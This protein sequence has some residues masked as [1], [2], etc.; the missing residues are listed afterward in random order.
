MVFRV[1][2]LDDFIEPQEKG[3]LIDGGLGSTLISIIY[4]TV[5]GI[6]FTRTQGTSLG[7]VIIPVIDPKILMGIKESNETLVK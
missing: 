6:I 5:R 2:N 3:N 4:S 1:D 7:L